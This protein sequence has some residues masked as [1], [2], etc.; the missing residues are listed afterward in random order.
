MAATLT[1]DAAAEPRPALA[2]PVPPPIETRPRVLLV[3]TAF[4]AAATVMVFA[5]LLGVYLT[6]R[7]SAV[8]GG[9]KWIPAGVTMPLTQPNMMLLTLIMSVVTVQWAVVAIKNDDRTN[10]Y[11]ALG[12]S[13]ILGFAFIVEMGYLYSIMKWTLIVAPAQATLVYVITGAHLAMLIG[14]M[15]FVI[16]MGFRALAGQFTSRQH[17]GI[18][19]AALYWHVMVAVYAIIWFAIFVT[20]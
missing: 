9:G 11:L 7:V 13:L 1:A 18:A 5:G 12:V 10:T 8:A 15:I 17:D 14:S 19:A 4:G 6:D 20:K 2:G 16:L 3:G